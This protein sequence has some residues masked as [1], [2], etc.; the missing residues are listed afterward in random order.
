MTSIHTNIAAKAALQTLRVIGSNMADTQQQ[1][2]SGLR[3]ETATDNAAYWSIST[4]MRSDAKAMAAASDALGLGAAS[5]DVAYAGITAVSDVLSEFKAKLIAAKEAGVDRSKI[6]TE[7]A[8][9]QQ[10]VVSSAAS[11]SFSGVNWLKTN[12]ADIND[13]DLDK[14]SILSSFKR[15][16]DGVSVGTI[17]FHLAE[18]SLFNESGGGLLQADTRKMK[19]LGGIRNYDT[20]MDDDGIIHTDRE[21]DRS[22]SNARKEFT[23]SGPLVFGASDVISFDVTVDADNP[24][25]LPPAYSLGKTTHVVI[26]RAMVDTRFPSENGVISTYTQYISL[27]DYALTQTNSGA[28]AHALSDGH[29]GT[30]PNA[31]SIATRENSGLD[32]SSLEISNFYTDVGSGGLYDFPTVYGGLGSEMNLSF[33][34]FELYNDG[35][36]PRGVEVSVLFGVNGAPSSSS[37]SFDR[38]YVNNLLGKENGKIETAAEMVTLLQSLISA[39]WPDVIIEATSSTNI[40]IRTDKNVDRL[41]G[42]KTY[43]GFTGIDVSIEPLAEQNFLDIDIVAYPQWLDRYIGYI[44]TVSADVIGAGAKLGALKTHIDLQQGFNQT[45]METV[46]KG[47]GRLIDADM[48]EAST[49]IRALE[50]QQQLATQAL[51][52]ANKDADNIM[53]LFQ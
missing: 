35:D 32:G 43:I 6:Q 12:I 21:N 49:R 13:S 14:V 10:Q 4:T 48:N 22:G 46:S 40:S 27:L 11:A 53:Q 8:Q 24:A 37:Y 15:S 50:T 5:V 36:N 2:S 45:L 18:I 42:G 7:L 19:T 44:E 23:F 39:D 51:N 31:I 28:S 29:G 3:V 41:N 47:V 26:D 1:V 16:N 9:L 33:S 38:S 25:I 52:I 30:V 34:P 17:D 20:F